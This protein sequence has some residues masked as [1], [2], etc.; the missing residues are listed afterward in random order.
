M[1]PEHPDSY[2]SVSDRLAGEVPGAWKPEYENYVRILYAPTL[3]TDWPRLA[4]VRAI[5]QGMTYLDPVVYDW[6]HI[7]C[8]TLVIGGDKDG[9]DFPERAKHIADSIPNGNGT[10][11]LLPNLGHVPHLEA[12]DLFY[13]ALLKFLRSGA[14]STGGAN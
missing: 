5:T 9:P 3:S 1:P 11:V 14:A 2:Y 13:P 6:E 10:L 8:K 12:P 7:K 4:M